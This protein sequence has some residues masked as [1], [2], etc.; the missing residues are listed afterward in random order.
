M[1]K[2]KASRR[3]LTCLPYIHMGD[4]QGKMSNL[5]WLR[6]W[7]MWHHQQRTIHSGKKKMAGQRTAVL[8]F[9]G[10]R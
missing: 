7:L 3:L 9:H 4:T 1:N 10:Q 6:T 8:G 2:R 5:R